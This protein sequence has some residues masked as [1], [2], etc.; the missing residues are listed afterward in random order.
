MSTHLDFRYGQPVTRGML[1]DALVEV[2]TD[3]HR[4]GRSTRSAGIKPRLTQQLER[5]GVKFDENLYGFASFRAFLNAAHEAGRVE[6]RDAA[7]GPDVDVLLPGQPR[8]Q[9]SSS[10]SVQIRKDFWET[11]MNWTPSLERVYDRVQG[12]ALS[13][14]RDPYAPENLAWTDRARYVPIEPIDMATQTKWATTFTNGLSLGHERDLLAQ[15]LSGDRPLQEFTRRIKALPSSL[16]A[17]NAYRTQRVLDTINSWATEHN[18]VV[19]PVVRHSDHTSNLAH[20]ARQNKPSPEAVRNG[21][22]LAD[23]STIGG[24]DVVSA[25]VE[26]LRAQAHELVDRMTLEE[27]LSLPL[28]LGLLHRR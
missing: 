22:P 27:L 13:R 1:F 25:T 26:A 3:L 10:A 15:A 16:P 17:W 2:V 11:F 21:A 6:L 12:L 19:D 20:P 14:Q 24:A 4:E 9:L 8:T 28:T 23:S 5:W 18:L 7:S